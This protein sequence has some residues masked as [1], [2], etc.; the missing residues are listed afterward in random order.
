VPKTILESPK[1]SKPSGVFSSG[2]KVPAGQLVFVSGQVARNA[3]GETVGKGDIKAQTRQVLENIKSVLE[4]AGAT[5]DDVVKVSVFVTNLEEHF[6]QIH[7]VRA[8]YFK[9]DYPAS[10]MVEVKAL[11]SKELLIE[12]EAVAVIP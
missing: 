10:T 8:Q 2:V 6:S 11:A 7:E 5:M 12:I 1:L 4:A 3:Q 9:Q